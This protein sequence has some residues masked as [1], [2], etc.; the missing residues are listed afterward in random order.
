MCSTWL[1]AVFGAMP[2]ASA[3]SALVRPSPTSRATSNSR[4]V[5]GRHGSSSEACPR[6]IRS[7]TSARSDRSGDSS[8]SAAG[9][10]WAATRDRLGEPVRADQA[11]RQVEPGRRWPPTPDRAGPS[12]RP[13]TRAPRGRSRSPPPRAR[14]CPRPWSSAAPATS[15]IASSWLCSRRARRLPRSAGRP[16]APLARRSR[17]TASGAPARRP[18][19]TGRRPRDRWRARGPGRRPAGRPRPDPTAAAG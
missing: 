19:P 10:A 7:S 13:P 6:A 3:I 1:L 4:E 14:R 5:S 18:R 16:G 11:V 12:R 15:G 8:R 9:R 17:R 2:R